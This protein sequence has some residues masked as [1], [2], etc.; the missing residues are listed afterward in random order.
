MIPSAS[1][2][3]VPGSIAM[4]SWHFSAV[5]LRYGSIATSFAPRRLASCARDP[6]VQ[7]RGDRIAA[8]DEDQTAVD[9]L[10]EIH[11]HRRADD[12]APAGLAGGRADRA[13]E[14]RRAQPVEE[15]PVHRR[16]A[17]QQAHRARR[18]CR[19]GSP[20]ARHRIRRS[21]GSAS[22]ISSSASSQEMRSKRPSPFAPSVRIGW[23]H[24]GR[25]N[26]CARDSARPWCTASRRSSDG[27]ARPG[28][29]SP[30]RSRRSRASRR[31][32]GSR[33]DT[34][35]APCGAKFPG[36]SREA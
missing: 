16:T 19:A 36:A 8:P 6:E 11:A 7:V 35:P 15:P 23:Q 3:S 12:G 5:R 13:V 32:R 17:L 21:R 30:G 9:V 1:A 2:P 4:C 26:T 25:A 31:C 10:L 20:A 14:Q 24:G 18:S 28:F 27:P 29:R 34:P 22:A 33:A